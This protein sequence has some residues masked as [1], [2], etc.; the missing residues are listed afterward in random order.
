[1]HVGGDVRMVGEP[2]QHA[3]ERPV[4]GPLEGE[5]AAPFVGDG[6]DAVDVGEVC[7]ARRRR[8]T[9]RRC[10]REV[11]AEQFTVLMTAT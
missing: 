7:A 6:E 3:L 2:R 4:V 8:E 5:A 1:M 10:S 9:G 11:L